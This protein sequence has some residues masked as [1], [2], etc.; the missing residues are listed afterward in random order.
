M[1][2]NLTKLRTLELTRNEYLTCLPAIPP[3]AFCTICLDPNQ[4]FVAC[5]AAVTVTPTDVAMLVGATVPYT[6]VLDEHPLGDVLV[7]PASGAKSIATVPEKG[8]PERG[9]LIFTTDNWNTPQTVTV[10]G[11]AAGVATISHTTSG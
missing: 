7:I 5:G 3:L 9:E 8:E 4:T 1:F 6:V 10:T 2:D 11:V